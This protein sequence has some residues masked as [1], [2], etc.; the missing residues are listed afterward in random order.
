M[1]GW[2]SP[3]KNELIS[4]VCSLFPQHIFP[5]D[6]PISFHGDDG[7]LLNTGIWYVIQW[8]GLWKQLNTV[9][10]LNP[11]VRSRWGTGNTSPV[12]PEHLHGERSAAQGQDK[13]FPRMMWQHGNVCANL[14]FHVPFKWIYNRKQHSWPPL[15]LSYWFPLRY[16]FFPGAGMSSVSIW[17]EL[18]EGQRA[19]H[20]P[21]QE[22]IH[23]HSAAP[24]VSRKTGMAAP[25]QFTLNVPRIAP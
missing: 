17:H 4:L 19:E 1:H 5:R 22:L 24:M 16:H 8:V 2:R 7:A 3:A 14:S 6:Q 25:C 10:A 18:R 12:V 11:A 9:E 13:P 23:L 15:T 20:S 21:K